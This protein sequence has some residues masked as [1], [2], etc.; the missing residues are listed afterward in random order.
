MW[1]IR[2][3]SL[4]VLVSLISGC[5]GTNYTV[6]LF[7]YPPDTKPHDSNWEYLG[8]IVVYSKEEGPLTRKSKKSVDI[9]I[10]D[11]EQ[12]RVLEDKHTFDCASIRASIEW[13]QFENIHIT[14]FEEGNEFAEDSYNKDLSKKG[15]VVL[16][17]LEYKFN[18]E[19]K[20]F[21]RLSN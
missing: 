21:E 20:Q 8:K 6:Q 18:K 4:F 12:N 3:F 7:S 11:R 16:V 5:R 15:R 2:V 10:V 9:T 14:L 19:T 13:E 1:I 17:E